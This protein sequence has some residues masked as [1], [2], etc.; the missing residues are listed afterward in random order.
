[1][2]I[3]VKTLSYRSEG[4]GWHEMRLQQELHSTYASLDTICNETNS[5]AWFLRLNCL[6]RNL[7][8]MQDEIYVRLFSSEEWSEVANRVDLRTGIFTYGAK[9]ITHRGVYQLNYF[10]RN[11]IAKLTI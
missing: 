7:V 8:Y 11:E 5:F 3:K 1:M 6:H 2:K 10:H 9:T 4:P